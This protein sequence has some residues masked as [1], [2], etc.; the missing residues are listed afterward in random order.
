MKIAPA[1]WDRFDAKELIDRDG[2]GR[3]VRL[4]LRNPKH[5]S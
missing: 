4:A 3:V 1:H 2:G 5:G